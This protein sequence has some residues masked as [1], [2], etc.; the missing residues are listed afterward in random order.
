MGKKS[1]LHV[2]EPEKTQILIKICELMGS[3]TVWQLEAETTAAGASLLPHN[4]LLD[5]PH[6]TAS[7]SYSHPNISRN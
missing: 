1:R 4:R 3:K 5:T 2:A 7:Y 6:H